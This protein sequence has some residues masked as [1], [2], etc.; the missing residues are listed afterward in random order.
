[1]RHQLQSGRIPDLSIRRHLQGYGTGRKKNA[2][3]GGIL[4]VIEISTLPCVS[5]PPARV[6]RAKLHD[7]RKGN[8]SSSGGG[9]IVSR[10][11]DYH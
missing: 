6:P 8:I 1:M 9:C 10:H 3:R 5:P 4:N 7:I 2:P 11:Y